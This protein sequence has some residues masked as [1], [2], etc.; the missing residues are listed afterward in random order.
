MERIIVRRR[1]GSLYDLK[2]QGREVVQ[3]KQ[4]RSFMEEDYVEV[5]LLCSTAPGIAL[6]DTLMCYGRRYVVNQMPTIKKSGSRDLTYTVRFEGVQYRLSRVAFL[7]NV[8]TTSQTLQDVQGNSLIGDIEVHLNALAANIQR[9]FPVD[10]VIIGDYPENTDA[11][12]LITYEDNENCLS[13]LQKIVDAFDTEFDV[14]YNVSYSSDW[15]D[16]RE[17]NVEYSQPFS[18]GYHKGLYEIERSNNSSDNIVNKLWVY[19]STQNLPV[20]YKCDRLLLPNSTKSTS[21][22]EDAASIAS[23][24]LFEG[25]KV[26]DDIYPKREG[27][28][29]GVMSSVLKFVDSAMFDLNAKWTNSQADYAWYLELRG[30][31]DSQAMQDNYTQHVVGSTKYLI[32]GSS[33]TIHFNS[34]NLAGYDFEVSS[35]NSTTKE[36]TIVSKTDERGLTVPNEDEAAFQVSVGDKYTLSDIML[37]QSYLTSAS[38]RLLTKAED[39]LVNLSRQPFAYKLSISEMFIKHY[40]PN[41]E[42]AIDCGDYV[43]LNDADFVGSSTRIRVKKVE[44]DLL[45]RY[46]YSLELEDVEL[47][48]N[49]RRRRTVDRLTATMNDSVF[50]RFDNSRSGG[51]GGA[52]ATLEHGVINEEQAIEGV[53]EVAASADRTYM[54]LNITGITN[55]NLSMNNHNEHY[56]L[57]MNEGKEEKTVAFGDIEGAGII[58]A[59]RVTVKPGEYSEVRYIYDEGGNLIIKSSEL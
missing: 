2:G 35:F 46:S 38:Q 29:T 3:A 18:Y 27:N 57:L 14:S 51:G 20:C 45:S 12:T 52:S 13:A 58:G 5:E 17:R 9:A 24:G 49:R 16:I 23:N 8:D 25:V 7:L 22:V 53:I 30:E 41:A 48:L 19:G 42:V 6:G 47:F 50:S 31:S 11:D 59:N 15:I 32:A 36:F 1:D 43:R 54:Q 28:V 33:A 21:Y 56:L 10:P 4:V 39:E 55:V 44:R 37:P 26:Y 34:G 40:S